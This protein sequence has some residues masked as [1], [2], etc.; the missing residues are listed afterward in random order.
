MSII[1]IWLGFVIAQC[2]VVCV[3]RNNFVR[4]FS[5]LGFGND[6]SVSER[7]EWSTYHFI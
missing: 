6:E 7:N 5:F 4:N 1:I 2:C 3:V